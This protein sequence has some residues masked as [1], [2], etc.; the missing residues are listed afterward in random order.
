[1]FSKEFGAINNFD[2]FFGTGFSTEARVIKKL[3]IRPVD[4]GANVVGR[5]LN[6]ARNN[7]FVRTNWAPN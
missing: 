6:V 4:F 2:P 5:M 7:S 3:F 1:M